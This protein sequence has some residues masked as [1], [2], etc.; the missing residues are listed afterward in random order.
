MAHLVPVLLMVGSGDSVTD[1]TDGSSWVGVDDDAVT[2]DEIVDTWLEH[3]V[4]S[5]N[6][7]FAVGNT[8]AT[9]TFTSHNTQAVT[10]YTGTRAF[11]GVGDWNS[12]AAFPIYLRTGF[13]G[14]KLVFDYLA[15]TFG[16]TQNDIQARF[17][18]RG[19]NIAGST[20]SFTLTDTTGGGG[21]EFTDHTQ[22]ITFD[23][24][25]RGEA[26]WAIAIIEIRSEKGALYA[27]ETMGD[28]IIG[29]S[30]HYT[31]TSAD[32]AI[33]PG[34]T[35][36]ATDTYD[37][38]M[39][40]DSAGSEFEILAIDVDSTNPEKVYFWPS[41]YGPFT[42]ADVD[43]Y[44]VGFV[45]LRSISVQMQW[46]DDSL[47]PVEQGA[48]QAN[49]LNRGLTAFENAS[50]ISRYNSRPRLLSI[51]NPGVL[52]AGD[53]TWPSN[54]AKIWTYQTASGSN[55]MDYL[56]DENL[57]IDRYEPRIRVQM[58]LCASLL[59]PSLRNTAR[60]IGSS[61][62]D[63]TLRV[64][65]LQDG[66]STWAGATTIKTET[67]DAQQVSTYAANANNGKML[68][69]MALA[70][71]FADFG[72]PSDHMF[73]YRDG[74]LVEGDFDYLQMMQIETELTGFDTESSRPVRLDVTAAIDSLGSGLPYSSEYGTS[75]VQARLRLWCVGYSIWSINDG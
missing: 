14:I 54:Y 24:P 2:A 8:A 35:G 62:W 44:D 36:P 55:Q 60:D 21:P 48:L 75:Y 15:Y 11:T 5:N 58:L 26:A 56:I 64:R 37:V 66:D 6:K 74:Q 45:G 65:Q 43:F 17:R 20:E 57:F 29:A 59:T 7:W 27:S 70:S 68:Y 73:M 10:T 42:G 61:Y 49:T 25:Y 18:I 39:A 69:Q 33:T 32:G 9:L 13:S 30:R 22:A 41:D 16:A 3:R 67:F 53:E 47:S 1:Y 28:N 38:K 23:E 50:G 31:P 40:I 19:A 63:I 51:G 4:M 46:I 52:Y 71:T 12:V 34:S 72:T